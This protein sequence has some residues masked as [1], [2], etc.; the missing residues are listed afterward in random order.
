MT[1]TDYYLTVTGISKSFMQ[2]DQKIQVL[3]NL[4]LNVRRGESIAILGRSGS[5]KSTLLSLLCGLDR[6]EEGDISLAQT[7]F[8][9]LKEEDLT[10]FRGRKMGIIFQQFHLL[11][12]LT[13]VENVSLALEILGDKDA[14][15]KALKA[16]EQVGLLH[17]KDHLPLKLSGGEKQRVAIARAMVIQ[18]DLLLAD[19]PSGSLDES[20]GKDVMDLIFNLV[21]EN[22]MSLVLVTHSQE[23]A[24]RCD[25]VLLLD[26]GQLK[27]INR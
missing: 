27:G 8:S 3:K 11:P 7:W 4:D 15:P 23:L 5:G 26:E 10:L 13:A 17:R 25:K 20:T 24:N 14:G 6:P 2:G 19:E 1:Q 9:S 21:K 12:H 22:Q 16:L 18:P